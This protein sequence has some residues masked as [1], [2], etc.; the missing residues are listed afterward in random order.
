MGGW[1][2]RSRFWL[3]GLI[4]WKA[5]MGTRQNGGA[6]ELRP[7]AGVPPPSCVPGTQRPY[8]WGLEGRCRQV[9]RAG[10]VGFR[11]KKPLFGKEKVPAS[12]DNRENCVILSRMRRVTGR[13]YCGSHRTVHC[14]RILPGQ[15]KGVC[16]E[17]FPEPMEGDVGLRACRDPGLKRC[18]CVD[19]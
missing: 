19:H 16:Y 2:V 8:R 5:A 14:L 9:G 1:E 18:W 3:A 17:G 7:S 13:R 15:E 11:T 12:L 10:N 4:V 6:A